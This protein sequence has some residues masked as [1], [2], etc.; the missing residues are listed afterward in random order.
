MKMIL[1][2]A[3]SVGLQLACSTAVADSADAGGRIETELECPGATYRG[4]AYTHATAIPDN[5][6]QG[7]TI[8]PVE[9]ARARR[10]IHDLILRIEISHAY[11]GDLNLS[12]D[13]DSDGDGDIDASTPIEIHLARPTTWLREELYGCPIELRGVYYFKDDGWRDSG[14]DAS[15]V[16]FRGLSTGGRFYLSLVDDAEGNTGSVASWA[17]YIAESGDRGPIGMA[18]EV[19]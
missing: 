6:I 19:M 11:A 18:G 13:Y 12:L 9:I 17:V 16:V 8:G 15:L 1:L 2:I 14:E 4:Y 7:I 3:I 10:T 5:R